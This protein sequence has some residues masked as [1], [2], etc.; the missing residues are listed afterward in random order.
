MHIETVTA[1]T[2]ERVLPLIA[3]YQRFYKA[4]PEQTR[5]RAHFGR[6]LADHDAGI[7]FVALGDDDQALGFATLYFPLG[8]VTPGV[9][10]LM[11][12]LFVVPETR[13]QGIGRALILHC[14]SYA[15]AHGFAKI[16]WQTALDNH[17]AQRL[18]D[19]L[20]TTRSGWYT[21]RLEAGE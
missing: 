10:C 4:E 5:N 13:S 12:D 20:P 7:Q 18:Y 1:Q 14:L 15:K 16:H 17:T 6:L 9:A 19:S 2:F 3:A 8:S 21:Y 11:N